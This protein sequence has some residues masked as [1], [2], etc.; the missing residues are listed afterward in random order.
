MG[1]AANFASRAAWLSPLRPITSSRGRRAARL[2]RP[3]CA[4]AVCTATQRGRRATDTQRVFQ[5]G[6]YHD[7]TKHSSVSLGLSGHGLDWSIKP[8]PFKVYRDLEAIEAPPDID[9]LCLLSNGVLRWRQ[10]GRGEA[11]GFRAAPCT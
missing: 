8:L 3:T 7:A 5:L 6:R 10:D 2:T 11:Y 9:R 4:P 1:A